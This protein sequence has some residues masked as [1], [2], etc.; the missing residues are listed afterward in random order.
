MDAPH[1]PLSSFAVHTSAIHASTVHF[2]TMFSRYVAL[3]DS[4]S[5][6]RYPSLDVASRAKRGAAL[7]VEYP[8]GAASLLARN[9]AAFWPD[10]DGR[11]LRS[12]SPD[13][14]VLNLAEDDATIGDVF[15]AQLPDVESDDAGTLV[16]LTIGGND[17]LSAV[18]G[19]PAEPV[20]A[21]ITRDV[22]AAYREL[23]AEIRRRLPR[24]RLLLSTV[25]DPTDRTAKLPGVFPDFDKVPLEHLD[26]LNAAI[27]ALADGERVQVAEVYAHFLGHGVT[28]PPKERW[29]WR[30][31]LIEP[32]AL[33]ASEIRRAWLEAL[34][35]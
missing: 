7:F 24:A 10:F 25:Y 30:E 32:S 8:I 26:A 20:M 11:D 19:R 33:G 3:G 15:I 5:I 35:L 31:S 17:L 14:E 21:R 23:V 4:M 27:R 28:V 13:L 6:D 16:T 22:I 9:D 34:G 29:Y 12:A 18:A 1:I 2:P